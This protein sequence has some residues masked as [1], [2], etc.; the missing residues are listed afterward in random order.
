MLDELRQIAIFAKTVDHGSFRAAG[1]ALR[2][3]PSVVSHHVGQLEQSLG[4]A[5]LYRSTRKLSLTPDG[6]R[7]LASAYA[8]IEAAESGLQDLSKQGEQLSGLL[9]LTVP[10]V[11]TQSCFISQLSGFS[12]TYPEV[13]LSIDLSDLRR[14]LISDG[15]DIAIS[16]GWLK[17]S[18]LK[19]KKLFEIQRRL[20]ASPDYIAKRERP[21]SPDDLTDWDWLELGPVWHRK[22]EF[23][24]GDQKKTVSK[25]PSRISANNAD[26]L[27][28]LAISGSGLALIPDFLTDKEIAAGRLSH[29]LE[30]WSVQP[31]DVFAVWPANAPKDGLIKH[32]VNFLSEPMQGIANQD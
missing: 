8:M 10:A 12:R 9:R 30:E 20:V 23:R 24:K 29:V 28:Q 5:L 16:I 27:S 7:L 14:D 2:L 4:T 22:P 19:A 26:A 13:R 31:L 1:Q 21:H 6:E 25:R 15:F 18:S 32:F 11:M 17:D 3:S